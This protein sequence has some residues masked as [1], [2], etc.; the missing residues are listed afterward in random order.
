MKIILPSKDFT[1]K[2]EFAEKTEFF[3]IPVWEKVVSESQTC[4]W[5]K[6]WH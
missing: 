6:F 1:E 3:V 5:S 4:F 2:K